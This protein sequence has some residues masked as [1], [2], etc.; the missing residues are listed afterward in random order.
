[1]RKCSFFPKLRVAL[2]SADQ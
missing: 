1:M 2:S